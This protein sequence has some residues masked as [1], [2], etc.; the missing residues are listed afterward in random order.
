VD[1]SVAAEPSVCPRAVA[2]CCV[3]DLR[4]RRDYA[5]VTGALVDFKEMREFIYKRDPSFV[6]RASC[7]VLRTSAR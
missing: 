5:E 7:A 6:C 1:V 2:S 4:L 3:T